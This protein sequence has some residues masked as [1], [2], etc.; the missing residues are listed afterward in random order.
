MHTYNASAVTSAHNVD[1]WSRSTPKPDI[2]VMSNNEIQTQTHDQ[3]FTKLRL[4]KQ[5]TNRYSFLNELEF[6]SKNGAS[7][8][9]IVM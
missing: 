6:L 2:P 5:N 1:D 8:L 3:D 9:S 4:P 7:L